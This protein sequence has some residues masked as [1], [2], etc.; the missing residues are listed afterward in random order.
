MTV[1][2]F[3]LKTDVTVSP[4]LHMRRGRGGTT[5]GQV[6]ERALD[7]AGGRRAEQSA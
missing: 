6:V 3:C 1:W 5:V 4:G 7:Y 2:F